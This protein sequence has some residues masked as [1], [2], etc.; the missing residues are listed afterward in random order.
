MTS[1]SGT[2]DPVSD[3]VKT[4]G[5]MRSQANFQ[6][7]RLTLTSDRPPRCAANTTHLEK[8]F[9]RTLWMKA[10]SVKDCKGL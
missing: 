1:K 4:A 6:S 8:E 2:G 9:P 3:M 5:K 7:V 10:S